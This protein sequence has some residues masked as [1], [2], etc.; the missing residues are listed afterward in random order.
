MATSQPAEPVI[1]VQGNVGGSIVNG[2]NNFVVNTNNG[3]IVY[4]QSAP[5]VL[6]RSMMPRAPRRPSRF[7]GRKK[8][9][10]QLEAWIAQGAPV[11]LSGLA[12]LGK[13]TLAKQAA[14]GPAA[15]SRP[16]GVV[17]LEG[18]DEA[19]RLLGLA[20]TVQRLFNAFFESDP[21]LKVDLAVARTYL[22]NLKPLVYLSSI[23][24]SRENLNTLADL[25]PHSPVLVEME[26]GDPGE[27]YDPLALGPLMREDS[28]ALIS[29]RSSIPADNNSR[30]LFSEIAALLGDV[31]AALVIVANALRERGFELRDAPSILRR[32]NPNAANPIKIALQR[33]YA[34][35]ISTLSADEKNMLMQ[36]GAAP[37]ISVD[38]GWLESVY[39]G[40][41]VSQ[42]LEALQLLQ[43]NSPRLRLSSGLREFASQGHNIAPLKEKLLV[44]LVDEMKTRWREFDFVADELG[45][46]LG[47][48]DWAFTQH[49][50][51]DVL[52]LG[53]TLDP[54]LTLNGLWDIWRLILTQAYQA[55]RALGD[56]A[57]Q[58]WVLHQI[59][60]AQI[61][62]GELEAARKSL[63]QALQ[64]RRKLGDK[65][66]AA[67]TQHNL[68]QVRSERS[69]VTRRKHPG[70]RRWIWL[71]G[72][73]LVLLAVALF[74]ITHALGG[75]FP[76]LWP[77]TLTHTL[78][79]SATMTPPPPSTPTYTPS[80]TA[81]A[82]YTETFTP[83]A[84]ATPT[85]TS[86]PAYSILEGT[87]VE[88][89]AC[90]YGPGVMYLQKYGLLA[91]T[92]LNIVG[93]NK[94]TNGTWLYVQNIFSS[95]A[96]PCWVSGQFVKVAGETRLLA[97]LY[98]DK[99]PLPKS[100]D[101]PAPTGVLAIRSGDQVTI[102]WD[103]TTPIPL[104]M[105][106]SAKTPYY[107]VELW[108]CQKGQIVFTPIGA[109]N[110][111]V[112][113]TDEA[114][115]LQPSHG[116]L[117]LSDVDGYDGPSEIP[118]PPP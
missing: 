91:R 46:L 14:N 63:E 36:T 35:V 43:A 61:G 54:F 57:G 49:R 64:L 111:S 69:T 93:I 71:V 42:H 6:A 28:I 15:A 72:G 12:G 9:L 100:P 56:R 7:I 67:H 66:G 33:A 53:R 80:V 86:V 4:K 94:G 25:F 78:T 18:V 101:Y 44:H 52:T 19:G 50:W 3:T 107:L 22:S 30:P 110:S 41:N 108:T 114:G 62:R 5:R 102:S 48:M 20:D 92:N 83:S 99:A 47:L 31:P 73:G 98:P 117:F 65:T 75:Q 70:H 90:Y 40:T 17:F 21:P 96:N 109:F 113:V 105:R 8:E 32:V 81:S 51:R 118:W 68:E 29:D 59:G 38:R 106:E 24:L 85:F 1:V 115:C 2:D 27:S 89:V 116:R 16:N 95:A 112:T 45:N 97:P 84:T 37:G 104:G 55:A 23:S 60:T 79:P 88:D 34:A 76:F 87:V 11:L 26:Q 58:G 82:T 103:F 77:A 13:T 10:E 39:G 74:V